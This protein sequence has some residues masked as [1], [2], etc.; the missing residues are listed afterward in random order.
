MSH[1]A[2]DSS[3]GGCRLVAGCAG[4]LV[5][6]LAATYL[7]LVALSLVVPRVSGSPLFE[8]RTAVGLP[9][10]AVVG[11]PRIGY[12]LR[13]NWDGSFRGRRNERNAVRTN[14]HGWRCHEFAPPG[15]AVGRRILLLGD[16]ITMGVGVR[17]EATFAARLEERLA[18]CQVDNCALSGYEANQQVAV[19]KLM[20]PLTRPDTVVYGLCQN[21]IREADI[22]QLAKVQLLR[23]RRELFIA[24]ELRPVSNLVW[25]LWA[26]RQAHQPSRAGLQRSEAGTLKRWADPRQRARLAEHLGAL[27]DECAAA[28]VPLH[29]VVFPYTFQF[30]RPLADPLRAPQQHLATMLRELQVAGLDLHGVLEAAR[31]PLYLLGDN[32]HLNEAGHARVAQALADWL[33]PAAP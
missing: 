9:D 25:N 30:D 4:R 5:L 6:A 21:D 15:A 18:P 29:V 7:T 26:A 8:R 16:S 20:L 12:V 14:S 2:R 24:L 19:A 28:G 10:E 3:A 11:D 23:P 22:A 31:E 17:Q 1:L 13:P 32:C 27:R 33:R